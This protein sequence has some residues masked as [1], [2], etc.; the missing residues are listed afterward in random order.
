[1]TSENARRIRLT[2]NELKNHFLKKYTDIKQE[3][4]ETITLISP[5]NDNQPRS[6][7]V[8]SGNNYQFKLG[9]IIEIENRVK[10]YLDNGKI[11]TF[12]ENTEIESIVLSTYFLKSYAFK[13]NLFVARN[14]LNWQ[15]YRSDDIVELIQNKCSI[16]ILS[17]GRIKF[18]FKHYDTIIKGIMTIEYRSEL[19]KKLFVFGAHGGNSGEKLRALLE[20]YLLFT[21]VPI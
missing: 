11:I 20:E 8:K 1:M 10:N 13:A 21:E 5:L 16:R 19:H 17:T 14:Q 7:V 3:I 2:G 9:R 15:I 18:D 4:I 6:V 12:T